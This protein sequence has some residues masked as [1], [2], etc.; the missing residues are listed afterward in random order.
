MDQIIWNAVRPLD[1]WKLHV[2]YKRFIAPIVDHSIHL[3]QLYNYFEGRL[4]HEFFVCKIHLQFPF[5][6]DVVASPFFKRLE[7][8]PSENM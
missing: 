7:K 3:V 5:L 1:F 2:S 4:C 6:N 8:R